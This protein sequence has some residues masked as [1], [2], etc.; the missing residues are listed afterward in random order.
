MPPRE[1]MHNYNIKDKNNKTLKDYL[2]DNNLPI[3]EHWK[4]ENEMTIF[5]QACFGIIPDINGH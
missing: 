2:K 3:P 5:D 4:N 1:W